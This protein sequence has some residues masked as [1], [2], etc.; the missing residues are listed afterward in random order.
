VKQREI[1]TNH[2][3]DLPACIDAA[4]S[5]QAAA[6]AAANGAQNISTTQMAA[7]KRNS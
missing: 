6:Y 5:S 7:A 4:R 2:I 3:V 1:K